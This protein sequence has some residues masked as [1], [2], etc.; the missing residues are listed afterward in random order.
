MLPVG[1]TPTQRR[2][3]FV[4]G[5]VAANLP[6][7]DLI[8]TRI[9]PPPLGYL[10]HHRGHTHTVVGVL[11]QALLLGA[12][13]LLPAILRHAG[14][15]RARLWSLIAISLFGHLLLDSWNS[16]GIHPFWPLDVRWY[17]GD[18][19]Y[20]LEPWLWLLLGV[21]AALNTQSD[22]GRLALGAGLAVLIG[23]LAWFGMI[24]RGALL[25]LAVVAAAMIVVTRAWTPRRRAAV[26]LTWSILFV[27]MMF[28]VRQRVRERA[29]ASME[30]ATRG[31]IVD[32]VLS[33]Q[34][35]NPL[36][37]SALAV[38]KDERAG[39]YVS[40]RGVATAFAS[41]GCGTGRSADVVWTEPIR[42]SLARLRRLVARD[43]SV[44]A[45]MQFGRAPEVGERAIGDLRY[46]GATRDNFSMMQLP[47][48]DE[49]SVCPPHLTHWGMPRADLLEPARRLEG[50]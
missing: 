21:A 16:Y 40:T 22:R 33:P 48:A 42:Q 17:Y 36:C 13:C 27:A 2:I 20:I 50:T 32:L 31:R 24:P 44:R 12:V 3:F 43:C 39:E 10:L 4:A 28:G 14:P 6:D 18:A 29:F 11:V 8:Y 1:A 49:A 30:S 26:A 46:G 25:A 35:A 19:V 37:W 15:L 38:A 5:V 47:S 41:V 23:A 34:P 9:T 45:W 7:A